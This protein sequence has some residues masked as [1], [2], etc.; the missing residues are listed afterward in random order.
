M[1]FPGNSNALFLPAKREK[2][3]TRLPGAL[4]AAGGW[5]A[6]TGIFSFYASH[7]AD[8][9]RLYGGLA[10]VAVIMLW[11]YFCMYILFLGAEL[12]EFLENAK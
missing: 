7:T 4:G 9:S 12:N 6:F 1:W 5:I 3:R 2:L 10:A 11:L 8:Y